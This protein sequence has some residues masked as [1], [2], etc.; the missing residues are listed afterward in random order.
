MKNAVKNAV[1]GKRKRTITILCGVCL[2]VVFAVGGCEKLKKIDVDE[3]VTAI[4]ENDTT[5]TLTLGQNI[6]NPAQNFTTIEYS[7]PKAGEVIFNIYNISGQV[8]YTEVL[9]SR[10]GR[11]TINVDISDFAAGIYFYS[12]EYQGQKLTKKMIVK[13]IIL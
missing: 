6:P 9:Q 11:H 2:G 5:L 12:I 3:L 7:I 4:I 10:A 1:I 13:K 8:L